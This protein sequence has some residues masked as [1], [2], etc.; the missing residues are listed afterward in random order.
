MKLIPAIAA[1]ALPA[2]LAGCIQTAPVKPVMPVVK[3]VPKPAEEI[4]KSCAKHGRFVLEYYDE[5]Y[6]GRAWVTFICQP[7]FISK[8]PPKPPE[9]DQRDYKG[10][11]GI[12]I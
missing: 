11:E 4:V 2:I 9:V 6:N 10:P 8:Q 7:K 3:Q 12:S 5:E 1:I